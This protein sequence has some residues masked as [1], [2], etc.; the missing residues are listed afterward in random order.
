MS[1]ALDMQ[2]NT[3][4]LGA[5]FDLLL[6]LLLS[7]VQSRNKTFDFLEL[8]QCIGELISGNHDGVSI[9]STFYLSFT[10]NGMQRFLTVIEHVKRVIQP[11]CVCRNGNKGNRDDYKNNGG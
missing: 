1:S 6:W 4:K 7:Q 8:F 10:Q 5:F 2:Q 9:T 3:Q 11:D